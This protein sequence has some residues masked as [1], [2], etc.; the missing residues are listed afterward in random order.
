MYTIFNRVW[1][2]LGLPLAVDRKE[3]YKFVSLGS[4]NVEM[5]VEDLMF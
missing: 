1:C 3:H 4:E 2:E 5:E